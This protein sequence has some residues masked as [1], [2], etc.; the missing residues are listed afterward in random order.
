MALEKLDFAAVLRLTRTATVARL[1]E[2]DDFESGSPS[3]RQVS[4]SNS[5]TRSC[6]PT[7]RWPWGERRTGGSDQLY[8]L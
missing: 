5:C 8:N 4:V 2:R 3:R 6:R 7:T 1:L